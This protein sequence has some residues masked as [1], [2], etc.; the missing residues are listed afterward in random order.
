MRDFVHLHLH[1]EYSLLD[2]ACKI[3]PLIKACKEMGMK[4]IAITDHGVMN[5]VVEFYEECTKNDIK[6]VIGCEVYTAKRTRFNKDAGLDSNYGHLL[7]LAENN[8]GYHNLVKI[9]SKAFTEGYY[10]KPRVDMDLLR[11]Y[12]EG[13]ICCSACLGGDVP[14]AILKSTYESLFISD[15]TICL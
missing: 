10:Y 4:S 1:S 11:E 2:G 7:L 9:V 12:H 3:K 13:I 14:Q 6:P 15:D 5:G 8:K